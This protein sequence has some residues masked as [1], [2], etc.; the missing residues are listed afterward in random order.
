MIKAEL[1]RGD[2]L[3]SGRIW[4]R[5]V[6]KNMQSGLLDA[7]YAL[8]A[9]GKF[10]RGTQ[11]SVEAY[12]VMNG[13]AESGV[14]DRATWTRLD[15]HVEMALGKR[16]QEVAAMLL[17]FRGDLDWVHEREGHVGK[18]YWPGGASGVTLDPGVDLGHMPPDRVEA[19]F[20]EV[21]NRTQMDILSRV[22]GI[23]GNDART[24]LNIVPGLREIRITRTQAQAVMPYAARGY[25]DGICRRFEPIQRQDTPPSVQT[26]MLSLAYNRGVYNHHLEPLGALLQGRQ[27]SQFANT[28]GA[29]QQNHK[30]QGIR[31]R[32]QQEAAV[33]RAE[34]QFQ[35][36]A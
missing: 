2:G 1:R 4:L 12:Q 20:G 33:I 22:F 13:L 27:W 24:A 3:P 21:L 9:D 26:V 17:A 36:T 25:W 34:L 28:V 6:V 31:I 15:P 8:E 10:G 7:G 29:M 16:E 30:L 19:L 11:H 5:S 32:R 35:E 18:P 23:R 14:V